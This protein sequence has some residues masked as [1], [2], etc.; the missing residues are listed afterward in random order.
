MLSLKKVAF[1]V[2]NLMLLRINFLVLSLWNVEGKQS[3]VCILQVVIRDTYHYKLN[4]QHLFQPLIINDE[5]DS[6]S[7]IKRKGGN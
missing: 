6:N 4:L 5:S 1:I 3:F 2:L 7:H